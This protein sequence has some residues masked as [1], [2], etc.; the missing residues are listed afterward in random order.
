MSRSQ[1]VGVYALSHSL[2]G[3]A[4]G[5]WWSGCDDV[6]RLIRLLQPRVCYTQPFAPKL[7]QHTEQQPNY[8]LYSAVLTSVR[9]RRSL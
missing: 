1:T 4:E 5:V 8:L 2:Q 7:T 6:W 3:V 9:P